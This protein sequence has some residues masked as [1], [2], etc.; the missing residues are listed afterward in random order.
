MTPTRRRSALVRRLVQLLL[1][2]A[3]SVS[4]VLSSDEKRDNNNNNNSYSNH[5]CLEYIETHCGGSASSE[6][7]N[8][9]MSSGLLTC[10][11]PD[12]CSLPSKVG[13]C[14]A[15]MRRFFYDTVSSSCQEFTYGGCQGNDNNFGTQE[16][17]NEACRGLKLCSNTGR[18]TSSSASGSGSECPEN[19]A[20]DEKTGMCVPR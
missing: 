12:F 19:L 9:C 17:C 6:V 8:E 5:I 3:A 16:E 2:T 18:S 10:A 11:R 4:V 7:M 1:F 15:A 13:M 20:C 14:R